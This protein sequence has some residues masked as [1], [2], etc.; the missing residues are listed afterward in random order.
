MT[1]TGQ[2]A[3]EIMGVEIVD[4]RFFRPEE[5]ESVKAVI[6]LFGERTIDIGGVPLL[7]TGF[8]IGFEKSI[9][10]FCFT[11]GAEA[12]KNERFFCR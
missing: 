3:F 4:Q 2:T 8:E 10:S 1:S 7:K 11:I 6:F 5:F 9:E 12:S